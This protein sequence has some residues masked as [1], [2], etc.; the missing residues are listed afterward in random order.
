MFPLVLYFSGS[1]DWDGGTRLAD[2]TRFTISILTVVVPCLTKSNFSAPARDTSTIRFREVGPR[3]LTV[4][5]TLLP[6][7]VFVI[8]TLVPDCPRWLRQHANRVQKGRA[9][10]YS[11]ALE[12]HKTACGGRYV[13]SELTTAHRSL[14]CVAVAAVN[15]ASRIGT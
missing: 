2:R 7:F 8:L 4:A 3:S 9:A 5:S 15:R 6:F 1:L 14:P 10:F 13:A 11:P 12:G